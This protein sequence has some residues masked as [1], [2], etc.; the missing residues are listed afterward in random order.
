MEQSVIAL[1]VDVDTYVGT[2]DGVPRLLDILGQSGIKATFF[3]SMG[4]DNS[5]KVI[6]RVFT[7]KGFLKKQL[8]S[9][10]PSAYGLKTLLYGT[11]L[12]AP[13]I[14][15]SFPEILR[16]TEELGHEA[17]IHCWDHVKWH[18]F[19]PV[20]SKEGIA[21]ELG[22][23]SSL[24]A[25]IFGHRA[26]STAAPGW[27]MTAASLALQDSLGLAY[28]SD[29]RGYAPFYPLV[30]GRRFAT[31][32]IPTTWPT[33]D[34]IVGVNGMT[35]ATAVDHYISLV[36]PGLNVH[37]IHAELEGRAMAPD[38]I[39]LLRRLR[40]LK[41]RFITLAEVAAEYAGSAPDCIMSMGEI[42]GR[43]SLVAIQGKK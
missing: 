23:A 33:M 11:L 2:R 38:F 6:R 10:A 17:G 28:C 12:P 4:P 30:D 39:E 41:A 3:F 36:K 5:G 9:G 1:K 22:R 43:A 24:F 27:T 29:A 34:E 31:L 8:R 16:K 42:P 18:D 32:Q 19:L 40:E 20:M 15:A 14:A 21:A 13:M 26:R 35:P 7:L 25:E 37:T